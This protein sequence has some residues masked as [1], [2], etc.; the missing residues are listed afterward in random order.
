MCDWVL[1]LLLVAVPTTAAGAVGVLIRASIFDMHDCHL[2]RIKSS[3]GWFRRHHLI[4]RASSG[5][6]G[7]FGLAFTAR[8]L[9]QVLF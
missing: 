6:C 9:Y 1:V 4:V 5:F 8:C 7:A 2:A 3:N